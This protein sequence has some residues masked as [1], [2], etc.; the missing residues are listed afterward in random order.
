[1]PYKEFKDALTQARA[2][3][4]AVREAGIKQAHLTI[5]FYPTNAKIFDFWTCLGS[6]R[7]CDRLWI[8]IRGNLSGI[9]VV[10]VG[11]SEPPTPPEAESLTTHPKPTPPGYGNPVPWKIE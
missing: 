5:E 4:L 7:T 11:I 6:C 8:E 3:G 2:H 1:M 10:Q 9:E